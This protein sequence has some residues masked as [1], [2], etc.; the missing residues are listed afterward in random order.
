[1]PLEDDADAAIPNC[2]RNTNTPSR[3][4]SVSTLNLT[5]FYTRNIPLQIHASAFSFSLNAGI[6]ASY[7]VIIA[8]GS[9][10]GYSL[11]AVAFFIIL[12]S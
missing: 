4:L 7:P 2:G 6:T 5:I 10:E 9:S 8:S 11:T 1:M 12:N 3:I